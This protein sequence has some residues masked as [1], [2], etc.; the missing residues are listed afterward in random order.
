MHPLMGEVTETRIQDQGS[1]GAGMARS[2]ASTSRLKQH[3]RI[4][5][6]DRIPKAAT[7]YLKQRQDIQS[8]NKNYRSKGVARLMAKVSPVTRL[9]RGRSRSSTHGHLLADVQIGYRGKVTHAKS[10]G[11]YTWVR[12]G[13][14]MAA[15]PQLSD[16]QLR[17]VACFSCCFFLHAVDHFRDR[18]HQSTD[19]NLHSAAPK[20]LSDSATSLQTSR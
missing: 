9:S 6:S 13:D 8:S 10:L 14:D 11:S 19:K 18:P 3:R 12:V 17:I 20:W 1:M 15:W 4:Q 2:K 5:V 7:R 16:I